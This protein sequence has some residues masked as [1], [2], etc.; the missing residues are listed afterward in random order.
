MCGEQ[1]RLCIIAV[2]IDYVIILTKNE[3]E[4]LTIKKQLSNGFKMKGMG[5]LHY[6]LGINVQQRMAQW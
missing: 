5:E 2:Y 4:M 1:N 6:L 3:A